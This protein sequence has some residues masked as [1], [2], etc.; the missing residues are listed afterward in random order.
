MNLTFVETFVWVAR[1]KSFTLAAERVNA[2]QAAVSSRI[3][4]LER[5]LGAPLFLREPRNLQLTEAGFNALAR[6][7][8]LLAAE[9]VFV[10]DASGASAEPRGTL[11]LGVIDTIAYTWLVDL[12]RLSALHFPNLSLEITAHTSLRLVDQLRDG[13]LDMALIMGPVVE[14]GFSSIELCTY[15]CHW[16]AAPSL[17][18]PPGQVSLDEL[19][20]HP[21]LSFPK[22]SQPN[23]AISRFLEDTGPGEIVYYWANSLAT[24][25]RMCVEG[26]GVA[27]IPPVVTPRELA[28]GDLV[29]V[30]AQQP[31]PP[32][33]MHAV[34]FETNANRVPG[35]LLELAR[36]AAAAFCARSDPVWAWNHLP[37]E[38]R[39]ERPPAAPPPRGCA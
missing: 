22:G 29:L 28:R 1:L 34:T 10:E 2:T 20:A 26:L 14:P 7:E 36:E 18:L 17:P 38:T 11:R 27:T 39:L 35:T 9:A 25:I 4:A 30:D 23:A 8:A 6:A 32:M 3:A 15:A 5:Q 24:I 31:I 37:A 21:V 33:R 12:I 19:T 13:R 16:V